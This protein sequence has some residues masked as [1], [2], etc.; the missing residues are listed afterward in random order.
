MSGSYDVAIV[1]YGPVGQA[2]AILLGQRGWRPWPGAG[3]V[4]QTLG[5][6]AKM[7]GTIG[8]RG[9]GA[10]IRYAGAFARSAL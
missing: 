8:E 4:L 10:P 7:I 6:D 9:R 3:R 5:D 1:G 2:L